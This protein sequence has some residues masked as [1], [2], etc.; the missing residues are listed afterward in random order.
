MKTILVTLLLIVTT[1]TASATHLMSG[2]MGYE[3]IG[4]VNGLFRYR[5]TVYLYRDCANSTLMF[6]T[7]IRVGI[8]N[9]SNKGLASMLTVPLLGTSTTTDIYPCICKQNGQGICSETGMFSATVDLDSRGYHFYYQRCCRNTQVNMSDDEGMSLYAFMAD[10]SAGSSSPTMANNPLLGF[11]INDTVEVQLA[12]T[13]KDQ[14]SVVCKFMHPTIGGNS[15]VPNPTPPG[16]LSLPLDVCTYNAGYSVQKPFGNNGHASLDKSNLLKLLSSIS[17]RYSLALETKEYRAGQLIGVTYT[18]WQTITY[19][20]Q[21]QSG[22]ATCGPPAYI[23]NGTSIP[24]GVVAQ[25]Y[26]DISAGDTLCFDIRYKDSSGYDV[27]ISINKN[28]NG[29]ITFNQTENRNIA[30]GQ[31]CYYSHTDDWQS[32]P[33]RLVMQAEKC[34]CCQ[35]KKALAVIVINVISPLTVKTLTANGNTLKA[36]FNN[37]KL[38]IENP[39]NGKGQFMLLDIAG[40]TILN[41][42]LQ[43]GSANYDV[44]HLPSGIYLLTTDKGN[45]V[46]LVKAE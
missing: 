29:L 20:C 7:S 41:R 17:G 5:I 39:E 46:K 45:V 11:C 19:P 28:L 34:G 3:Y 16:S 25:D 30:K 22:Q 4:K 21:N 14:D 18:Q 40:K 8:Y 36:F 9:N 24:T 13:D 6:D 23:P 43:S 27:D 35:N 31:Y 37:E 10:A 15:I 44:Q 12:V 2:S 33:H 26:Y 38:N 32:S 1:L 42:Q